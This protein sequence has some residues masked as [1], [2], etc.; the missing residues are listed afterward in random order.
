MFTQSIVVLK[1]EN[2]MRVANSL[3]VS[4]NLF[5]NLFSFVSYCKCFD[6]QTLCSLSKI[7]AEKSRLS[8]SK[9][10]IIDYLMG[11]ENIEL[12]SQVFNKV[13]RIEYK[14]SIGLSIDRYIYV[15]FFIIRF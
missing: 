13:F 15:L 3:I 1:D 5:Q 10:D 7:M 8:Q 2:S 11:R 9:F 4:L 12:K 14:I 6:Y